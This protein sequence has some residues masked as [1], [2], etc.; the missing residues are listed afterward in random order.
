MFFEYLDDHKVVGSDA[1]LIRQ[2]L[3]ES[4]VESFAGLFIPH[5]VALSIRQ[6]RQV[7]N[8]FI[9]LSPEIK[10][11]IKE[12]FFNGIKIVVTPRRQL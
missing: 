4:L 6:I 5:K 8:V 2:H 12:T 7:F 3:M 9:R 11:E 1:G 10:N